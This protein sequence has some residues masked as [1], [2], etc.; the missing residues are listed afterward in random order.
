MLRGKLFKEREEQDRNVGFTLSYHHSRNTFRDFVDDG[1]DYSGKELPGIPRQILRAELNGTFRDF[2]LRL[3]Q[4]YTGAQWMNDANDQKYNAYAL[5]DLQLSWEFYPDSSPFSI[6]LYAGIRNLFDT[7]YASMILI[8]APSFG[9]RPPR[10]YY[11]GKP[12]HFYLGLRLSIH[13][14]S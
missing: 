10:Y 13:S 3:F 7:H 4:N 8:N 14:P 2:S 5:T 1:I 6:R 9:G 11:P 12:R